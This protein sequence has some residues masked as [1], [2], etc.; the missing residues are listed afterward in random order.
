MK[1]F[2]FNLAYSRTGHK[3]LLTT[4][5]KRDAKVQQQSKTKTKSISLTSNDSNHLTTTIMNSENNNSGTKRKSD[6]VSKIKK[7]QKSSNDVNEVNENIT[8]KYPIGKNSLN[9]YLVFF[10]EDFDKH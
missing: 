10:Y 7:I 5:K 3:T 8:T 2:Y 9:Q 1:L 4:P 6:Q